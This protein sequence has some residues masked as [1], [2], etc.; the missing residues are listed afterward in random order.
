MGHLTKWEL[1][2]KPILETAPHT[3]TGLDI[4]TITAAQP[5]LDA[6]LDKLMELCEKI[7]ASTTSADEI[8]NEKEKRED[9]EFR[10]QNSLP[11]NPSLCAS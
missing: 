11:L 3:L 8:E 5:K 9:L 2:L 6:L 1:C 4:A 7:Q 10:V